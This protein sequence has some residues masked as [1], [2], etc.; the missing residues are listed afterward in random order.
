MYLSF[1][2][3]EKLYEEKLR[4]QKQELKQLHEERQRLI[5]IQGKIQDL[6]WA[7]PDLQ[8]SIIACTKHSDT[9]KHKHTQVSKLPHSWQMLVNINTDYM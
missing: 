5:E 3:R 4:K 2:H 9:H 8:V 6:Q 7:C 1:K